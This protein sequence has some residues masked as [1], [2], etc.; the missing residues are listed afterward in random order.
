MYKYMYKYCPLCFLSD[1]A[2]TNH[3]SDIFHQYLSKLK[4]YISCR[5]V[6]T[7]ITSCN[8]T[9]ISRSRH[10]L[11]SVEPNHNDHQFR[12]FTK[13]EL[14]EVSNA[15]MITEIFECIEELLLLLIIY[16]FILKFYNNC[17]FW[18]KCCLTQ[19]NITERSESIRNTNLNVMIRT[20]CERLV[21]WKRKKEIYTISEYI[22]AQISQNIK[23]MKYTFKWI[24]D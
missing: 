5:S 4:V 20:C 9:Y 3:L 14:S 13:F 2:T 23:S 11:I 15:F 10:I 22:V 1:F 24:I 18:L 12:T 6:I 19:L 21:V 16:F 8:Y 17:Y 7:Q